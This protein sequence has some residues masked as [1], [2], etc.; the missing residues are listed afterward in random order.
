MTAFASAPVKVDDGHSILDKRKVVPLWVINL[1]PSRVLLAHPA[2]QHQDQK[3]EVAWW[4]LA[5]LYSSNRVL[6]T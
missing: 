1:D 6:N 2:L 5:L 3:W 4:G